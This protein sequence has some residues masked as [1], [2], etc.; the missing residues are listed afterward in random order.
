MA[1]AFGWEIMKN[2]TLKT[3]FGYDYY[4]MYDQ[5]Y[6][7]LTSYQA[8]NYADQAFA[9]HPLISLDNDVR[10][11]FRNTNTIN[12]DFKNLIKNKDY[13]LNMLLGH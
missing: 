9:D 7:G 6:Y 3:E 5:R 11:R 8:R 10:E 12:Y 1:G 4:T 2:L 13:S